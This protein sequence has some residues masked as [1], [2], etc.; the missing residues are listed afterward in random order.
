M[1]TATELDIQRTE[2]F[3]PRDCN[4][5]GPYTT[6]ITTT[7]YSRNLPVWTLETPCPECDRIE[8]E[9]RRQVEAEDA[10]RKRR[11]EWRAKLD[12]ANIPAR[13][14]P[15]TF[16]NYIARSAQQKKALTIVRSYFDRFD[17]IRKTGTNLILYGAPGC[18][19]THLASALATSLLKLNK[20]V[21]YMQTAELIREIRD[22]W[23]K[24]DKSEIALI[25]KF[26]KVD[27]LI[28]DEVGI[29]FGTKAEQ[30]LLFSVLDGRYG[31]LRP[32][33]VI[34]NLNPEGLKDYIGDRLFDRLL[35][36]GSAAVLFNWS[37]Y[38]RQPRPQNEPLAEVSQ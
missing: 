20:K 2:V 35:E 13:F 29:Q 25:E 22:T 18:G 16:E 21:L 30:D 33:L 34:S 12:S 32:T 1:K 28:L 24:S 38:R 6:T 14:A 15:C 8:T 10:E 31:A 9:R 4:Q 7:Q 5:H 23:G 19:K 11:M 37:S 36:T 27:L 3:E 17:E 26:K